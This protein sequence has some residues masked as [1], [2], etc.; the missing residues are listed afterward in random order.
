MS[1]KFEPDWDL[2]PEEKLANALSI[3]LCRHMPEWPGTTDEVLSAITKE[4][5][6]VTGIAAVIEEC[7]K[8]AES[9]DPNAQDVAKAIRHLKDTPNG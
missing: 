4:I 3:A 7:A 5:Y 1:E 2:L 6:E 9:I 8:V